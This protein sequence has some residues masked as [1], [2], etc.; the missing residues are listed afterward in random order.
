MAIK[1]KSAKR[2]S[3]SLRTAAKKAVPAAKK[4]AK[5]VVP[6]AKKAAK[7]ARKIGQTMERVGVALEAGA[8]MV[9][10]ITSRKKVPKRKTTR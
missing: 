1:K 3:N 4:A 9:E 8:D 7:R 10:Q 6:A 5:K 2:K